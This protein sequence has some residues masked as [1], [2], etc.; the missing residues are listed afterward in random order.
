MWAV[1]IDPGIVNLGVTMFLDNQLMES[2]NVNLKHWMSL[3]DADLPANKI[4]INALVQALVS[5]VRESIFAPWFLKPGL[6]VVLEN[7]DYTVATKNV[8]G[9]IAGVFKA[10]NPE[11]L[12]QDFIHPFTVS[13]FFRLKSKTRDQKKKKAL[14]MVWQS[15]GHLLSYDESDAY[16]NYV[17]WFCRVFSK[18][19]LDNPF[20]ED[21]P[22]ASTFHF[23]DPTPTECSGEL[24]PSGGVKDQA[25]ELSS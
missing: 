17:Y 12:I 4:P 3:K 19:K 23:V 18:P 5:W 20:L 16:L 25:P 9:I 15:T 24:L 14:G 8:P 21:S 6:I 1:S 10:L 22:H 2:Q 11:C 13:R 7:N